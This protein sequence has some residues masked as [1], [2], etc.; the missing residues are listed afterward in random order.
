MPVWIW[1]NKFYV[2]FC[3]SDVIQKQITFLSYIL[4]PQTTLNWFYS[5]ELLKQWVS[6]SQYLLLN[7]ITLRSTSLS[8]RTSATL[9]GCH[10][11]WPISTTNSKRRM[12]KT[13]T[14]TIPK[15][16]RSKLPRATLSSSWLLRGESIHQPLLQPVS[17]E[18]CSYRSTPSSSWGGW[19]RVRS[20][21]AIR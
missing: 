13:H 7:A 10:A 6:C 1:F 15:T 9:L 12:G 5:T 4:L 3:Y 21:C 17:S 19:H 16:A 11:E 2:L 8:Q 14:A 18:H 20:G